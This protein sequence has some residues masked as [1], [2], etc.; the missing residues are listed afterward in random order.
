MFRLLHG[1]HELKLQILAKQRDFM[2][3]SEL[4]SK[5]PKTSVFDHSN[6]GLFE[7]IPVVPGISNNRGLTVFENFY[8]Q[9]K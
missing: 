8:Q 6:Y 5:Y 3:A 1:K 2:K 4:F 9:N 7:R